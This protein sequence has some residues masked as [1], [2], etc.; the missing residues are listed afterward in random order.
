MDNLV[1]TMPVELAE[2]AP[3][4]PAPS[5]KP[6]KIAKRSAKKPPA[7]KAKEPAAKKR[8]PAKTKSVARAPADKKKAAKKKA[9]KRAQPAA[10]DAGDIG[11][12]TETERFLCEVLAD[13]VRVEKVSADSHFF[14]DLGAD[15]MVMAHF[16]ARVR[17]C[18]D[19][20]SIS[21]KDIYRHPTIRSLAAAV[22]EVAPA[23][24]GSGATAESGGLERALAESAGRG[25]EGR[26]RSARRPLL[27]GSRREL[28]GHGALLR[29][30]GKR[31]DLP[32]ISMKQVYA[33]STIR[34][35]AAAVAEPV[36]ASPVVTASASSPPQP[37]P[38][39]VLEPIATWRYVLCGTLQVLTALFYS[40]LAAEAAVRSYAWTIAGS[41]LLDVYLRSL[42]AT[43]A[44]LFVGIALPILAKWV[45]IGRWKPREIRIWSLAYYR[46]WVVKTLVLTNPMVLFVGTPLYVLYLRALGAKIGRNVLILSGHVPVCTDLL[47]I[48]DN[49]VVRKDSFFLCYRAHAGRIQIGPV[50]LGKDTVVGEL[51]VLD[52]DTSLGDGAQIGHSSSLHA[53]DSIPAGEHRNGSPARQK[54]DFDYAAVEPARCGRLR[55][56]IYSLTQMLPAVVLAPMAI[57]V[58]VQLIVWH[59]GRAY[60]DAPGAATLAHFGFYRDALIASAALF[61]SALI[62]SLLFAVTVPRLL[63][64]M[65]R[66]DK[67]Y[68]L[69]GFHCW[70]QQTIARLTNVEFLTLLFGDSSYI[71]YYLRAIGYDLST[72]VQ[73]GSNFGTEIKH[74]NPFLVTFGT[75]TMVAD[76]MSIINADY[77]SSSFR[78]SRV[79]IGAE[80]FFGNHVAYPSQGK[81]G[82]NC[83]LATKVMVPLEGEVREGV[84]LLGSPSSRFRER[85]SGT[86]SLRKTSMATSCS[87]ASAGRIGTTSQL[88]RCFC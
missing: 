73:T 24:D 32:S 16:C 41:G 53:G 68:P 10:A 58:V 77:S 86:V 54:T 81:T 25:A 37:A 42:L 72:I 48:G 49:A 76:A 63:N 62:L 33:N 38:L 21:M 9:A 79:T 13:L 74:D 50:R 43:N 6:V 69:Y 22:A 12:T 36:P 59:S 64:R 56:A 78:V 28:D 88:W 52:I 75:G 71:V 65:L 11:A 51:T 87:A 34:G 19:L 57:A 61:F 67:V 35:L 8:P 7:K 4:D 66:P 80:N 23:G 20:P 3:A 83:L 27:Q 17:K 15:S 30:G 39:E 40:G 26:T 60:F 47:T 55:R 14:R 44:L 84:G 31:A 1:D 85:S 45:L 18:P 82:D 46:F 2:S 29:A 5:R 70:A